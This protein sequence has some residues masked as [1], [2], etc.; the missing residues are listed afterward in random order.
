MPFYGD[1]SLADTVKAI[2]PFYEKWD[3][4]LFRELA[5]TFELP[6]KKKVK[7]LS[8]GMRTKFSL[9]L[10]L[11]HEAELLI[12]DEP[13]TGLDPV[14]RRELLT[15]LS[16][17]LQDERRS[18][19]FSTHITSDLERIADYVTFIRDGSI[20]L[21]ETREELREVWGVVRGEEEVISALDSGI[22]R[23]ARRHP[24]GLDVLTSDASAARR[25]LGPKAIVERASFED[26]VVLLGQ[27]VHH[28]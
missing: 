24:H 5:S 21:T 10:A 27:E 23:G 25:F 14:F 22:W 17:L 1:V 12:L 19:L 7:K 4:T 6:L 20:L 13:T 16:G 8:Q 28:A 15:G 26:I 3:E 11:S 9:A 2:S 18:V